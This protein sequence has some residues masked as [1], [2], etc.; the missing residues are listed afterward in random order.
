M[1]GAT[2]NSVRLSR[3]R[4]RAIVADL[5]GQAGV[6]A[7]RLVF[8]RRWLMPYASAAAWS[9]LNLVQV[10]S[11]LLRETEEHATCILAHELG[12]ITLGHGRGDVWGCAA[13]T[14]LAA[15]ADSLGLPRG[16]DLASTVALGAVAVLWVRKRIRE[17]DRCEA[18]ASA[19]AADLVGQARWA[20]FEAKEQHDREKTRAMVRRIIREHERERS[21][22]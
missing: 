7:P 19:W 9:D 21:S 6:K 20:A 12:H 11:L 15:G 17:R 5:A 14:A 8:C 4:V 3:D 1:L 22:S 10:G 18:E 2:R 13:I 16:W